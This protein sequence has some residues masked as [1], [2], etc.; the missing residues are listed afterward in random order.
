LGQRKKEA[1]VKRAKLGKSAI[2][3]HNQ[4]LDALLTKKGAQKI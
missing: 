4:N 1:K 3:M 2:H